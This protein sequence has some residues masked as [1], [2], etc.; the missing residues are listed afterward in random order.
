MKDNYDDLFFEKGHLGLKIWQTLV[1]IFSWAFVIIPV[2]IT[3]FSFS[4]TRWELNSKLNFWKYDFEFQTFKI[5]FELLVFFTIIGVIF[6][7][8]STIVQNNRREALSE[9]WTL[10]DSMEDLRRQE[11]FEAYANRKFGSKKYRES[12]SFYS[13]KEEDNLADDEIFN[14]VKGGNK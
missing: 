10:F 5:I 6:T 14:V 8:T 2:I 4:V 7:I 9:K 12:I 3:G 11:R 13:L 1:A